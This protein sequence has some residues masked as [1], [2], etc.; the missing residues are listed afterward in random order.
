LVAAVWRRWQRRWG[1]GC[2]RGG[3]GGG[4][5]VGGGGC[6]GGGS[7]GGGGGCCSSPSEE[8]LDTLYLLGDNECFKWSV[9]ASLHPMK[10][11]CNQLS[12]Y[13]EFT[14]E[15]NM[16]GIK[17]P[18]RIQSIGKFEEQNPTISV[19]VFGC[20]GKHVFPMRVTKERKRMNHVNLLY[21]SEESNDHYC[22]IKNFNRL[23]HSITKHNGG[24]H[25]CY[26]CL[27]HFSRKDILDKH[28][29]FCKEHEPGVLEMPAQGSCV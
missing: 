5:D 29:E 7:G 23:M 16:N 8:Q 6:G 1:G 19:N 21:L 10:T 22:W 28:M 4:G 3:G 24:K 12:N 11:N 18:M 20:S 14:N 27:S 25:F 2:G 17:S 26:Y 15:L 13:R 9:L